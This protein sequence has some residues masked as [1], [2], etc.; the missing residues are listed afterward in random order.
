MSYFADV[1]EAPPD[2]LL[3][4]SQ[5]VKADP[6]P[7]KYD[8]GIGVLR[9]TDNTSHEFETVINAAKGIGPCC[10]YP[11]PGG[12]D[13]LVRLSSELIFGTP[14]LPPRVAGV[15]TVG[16]SGALRVCAELLLHQGLKKMLLPNP[17]W[18]NHKPL[19]S[20]GGLELA[21]YRYFDAGVHGIDFEGMLQDIQAA[22]PKTSI[23]LQVAAHNPTGADLTDDQWDKILALFLQRRDLL[24]V[25][26]SAYQG[27]A[28]GLEED[29]RIVRKFL[30]AG[31][32]FLLCN[33]FSKNFGL[34]GE[35]VGSLFIACESP[36]VATCVTSLAKLK[37]R[38]NYSVPPLHGA[39]IVTT[40]L[41]S[42]ELKASWEKELTQART[43]VNAAHAEFASALAAGGLTKFA[44]PRF[45][46][47]A[48]LFLSDHQV[49]KLA[50][51]HAV[52][53]APLG[54]INVSSL[55]A[56]N[57]KAVAAAVVAVCK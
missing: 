8:L 22:P 28:R 34:Y 16:G 36:K 15:Q 46:L 39:K 55:D 13:E 3:S 52:Y 2:P 30:D 7:V 24:P 38:T 45:G 18:A 14:A 47:F 53:C 10:Y 31:L 4:I 29:V 42:P 5:R 57:A 56:A 51:D 19:L 27:L 37:I 21:E 50:T 23:M 48:Q 49:N 1:P 35:R 41:S 12:D 54:R 40:I 11:H 43:T 26:D 44:A 33:S 32:E 6:R 25:F 17:S 20:G 9:R